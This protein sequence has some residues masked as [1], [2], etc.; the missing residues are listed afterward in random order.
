MAEQTVRSGSTGVIGILFLAVFIDLLGFGIIIPLLPL[1]VTD[2][3]GQRAEVYGL[4]VASY[5]L[6]QFIFAPIWGR[7]SDSRGRRPIIMVGLVGT[8]IGFSLLTVSF[9]IVKTIEML[10]LSRI[11]AGMFTAATLPTAQAYIAD[12]TSGKDR[13]KGFGLIGAAF[14]LG[15]SLGPGIGGV[16]SLFDIAAPALFAT[17][18]A[19]I[20]LL[21]A[22]QKL[23][24]SLTEEVRA[25][26][27]LLKDKGFS[28][29]ATLK[30]FRT[31][32]TLPLLVM[33]FSILT[34]GFVG[35]ET[36]LILLGNERFG[37]D[38]TS[39]GFVLLAVGIVAIITQG[40][41]IKPLTERFSD[42]KL[43]MSGLVF[44]IIGFLGLS[45][46]HSIEE[47]IFWSIPLAFGSS[48]GNPTLASLISKQ[49]PDE[50]NGEILGV[51][52]GMSS[53]M[54]IFGPIIATFLFTID[55]A[56]PYYFSAFLFGFCF[57]LGL[58]LLQLL[59]NFTEYIPI[60]DCKN[61]GSQLIHG[62]AF[63]NNCGQATKI[64]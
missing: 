8:V 50:K 13:A 29:G 52:Q 31:T 20:N 60:Y 26:R 38:A 63:C 27:K 7:L 6:M 24:E 62:D 17:I 5:S 54:R 35:M 23:P 39:G 33:M 41:L 22:S 21:W 61:C 47:M 12:S 55:S 45:T 3:L 9:T 11:I 32:P 42:Q 49:A 56:L 57:I 34:V 2:G 46:V 36:T 58:F 1:F 25:Q 48:I 14:G 4:L 18:L 51:N 59:K 37:L 40:G 30:L 53:L 28:K 15:F 64:S 10:F 44:L 43:S 16:L 19:L